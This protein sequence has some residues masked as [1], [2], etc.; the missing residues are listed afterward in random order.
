LTRCQRSSGMDG[1]NPIPKQKV[2]VWYIK[3]VANVMESG[4]IEMWMT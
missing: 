1:A 2:C 3:K 4:E